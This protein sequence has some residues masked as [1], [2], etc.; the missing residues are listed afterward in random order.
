MSI[1]NIRRSVLVLAGAG[2]VALGGLF[3]GRLAAGAV[4]AAGAGSPFGRPAFARIARALDLTDDQKTQIRAILKTRATEIQDQ[5]KAGLDARR[6]LH[7]AILAD[8]IDETAIRTRA[9]DLSRVEANGAVLYAHL[10]AEVFPIL[11]AEQKQKVGELRQR[12]QARGDRSA[13]AFQ[14]FLNGEEP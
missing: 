7:D 11:T 6:A 1:R 13:K 8:P 2:A 4:P 3:A 12:M 14:N 9:A 10:R 5:M